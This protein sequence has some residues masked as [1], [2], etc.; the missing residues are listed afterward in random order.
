MAVITI[1]Y[2]SA[3]TNAVVDALCAANGYMP[4][5]DGQPNPE[6]NSAFALRM[7]HDYVTTGTEAG[8][9]TV[10]VAAANTAADADALAIKS[11]FVMG[12]TA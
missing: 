2:P 4:T 7:I 12:F 10:K 8:N 5:I 1:T 9:R 3:Y 6:T 11:A